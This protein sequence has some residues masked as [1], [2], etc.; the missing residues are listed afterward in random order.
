MITTA[1]AQFKITGW[2]ETPYKEFENGAKLTRATVTQAYEGDLIAHGEVEF[3]MSHIADGTATFVGYE[4]VTGELSGNKGTFI[5]Q[6]IG[7][8][9]GSGACSSWTIAPNSG[10]G[11]L[12]GISGQGNY[13][14]TSETVEMPFSYEF[15]AV[16]S[17]D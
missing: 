14:A 7:T 16:A 13:T 2:D 4:L 3:L 12:T 6:H 1:S 8:F 5:I 9:G 17:A 15:D 11:E 10:T